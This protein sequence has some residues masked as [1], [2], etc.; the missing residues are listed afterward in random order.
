MNLNKYTEK[1]QEAIL[2][3]QN[4]AGEQNHAAYASA[5]VGV[6]EFLAL[7]RLRMVRDVFAAVEDRLPRDREIILYCNCPNEASAAQ[8]ARVL[9]SRGFRQVRPLR[10]EE[11]HEELPG[12]TGIL[13]RPVHR[14]HYT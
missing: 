2:A 6:R 10:E 12:P 1:A 4:I 14:A 9:L 13:I 3:A 7:Q 5:P 8:A 11:F